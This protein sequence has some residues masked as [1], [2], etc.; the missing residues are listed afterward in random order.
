MEVIAKKMDLPVLYTSVKKIKR[1]YY[2]MN[3]EL[4]EE[5]PLDKTDGKMSEMFIRKL[6]RDII[7]QPETWLWSHRRWKHK[8]LPVPASYN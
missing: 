7:N 2:E 5:H 4:L 1:G 8:R 3:A 6:E